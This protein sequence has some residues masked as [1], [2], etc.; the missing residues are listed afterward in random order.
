MTTDPTDDGK[1]GARPPLQGPLRGEIT[2][3]TGRKAV[4]GQRGFP[5]L[6]EF[7]FSLPDGTVHE[8]GSPDDSG[9]RGTLEPVAVIRAASFL[10]QPGSRPLC[11]ICREDEPSHKEHVP[12]EDLGGSV[13]TM[14]C[15][16]CNNDLGSR[17]EADLQHWFDHALVEVTF[18]HDG[19]VPGRRRVPPV[20]PGV[21]QR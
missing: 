4:G 17:V 18:D 20:L 11:P 19:E 12:Q 9:R 5:A 7:A 3:V 10:R 13:M 1:T 2:H 21:R 6:D 8:V 14:T 15:Q 16:A